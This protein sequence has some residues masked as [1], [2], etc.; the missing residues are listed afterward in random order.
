V[1]QAAWFWLSN[2]LLCALFL[3]SGI[4]SGDFGVLG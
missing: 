3:T 1:K 4:F 2:L